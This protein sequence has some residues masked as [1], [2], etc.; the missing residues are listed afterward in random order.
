[1]RIPE[2]NYSSPR[3]FT[4]KQRMAL[5]CFPPVVAIAMKILFSTCRKEAR[6]TTF[7][8]NVLDEH[9]RVIVAVWHESM[10][11]AAHHYRNTGYHTLT[12]YSYDGE[13][14]A[15][16]IAPFGLLAVRGSSSR[17]GS[18]AL[19]D[20]ARALEHVQAVGFTLDGPRGPRRVAK[21][22]IAILAARTQTHIIPHAFT[23]HPAWRLNSWDRLPIPKPFAR[24]VSACGEPVPPPKDTSPEAVEATRQKTETELNR[25]HA[26]IE[27]ETPNGQTT[28]ID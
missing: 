9:A 28:Q 8:R 16:V 27:S 3:K 21:P 7:L 17:G 11:L 25:L 2:V 22:G 24:I 18:D 6:G 14:A 4:I 19:D 10:A 15:R 26:E 5:F 20:L 12:S 1:M 23:V 13:M